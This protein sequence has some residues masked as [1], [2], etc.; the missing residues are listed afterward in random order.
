MKKLISRTK[1]NTRMSTAPVQKQDLMTAP[2]TIVIRRILGQNTRCTGSTYLA[3]GYIMIAAYKNRRLVQLN[4]E[5][6]I[7]KEYKIV[8]QHM[9][10]N[11]YDGRK[12]FIF[13]CT[14]DT[15]PGNSQ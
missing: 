3:D 15:E 12:T 7:V 1:I 8:G 10:V 4:E 6:H 14:L 13:K 5:Y 9:D 11:V 2:I